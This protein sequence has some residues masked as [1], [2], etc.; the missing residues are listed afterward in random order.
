M[1]KIVEQEAP[2]SFPHR[3]IEKKK[4]KTKNMQEAFWT[5]F[6]IAVENKVL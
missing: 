4:K 6:I 3:N 2:S 5:N 1:R